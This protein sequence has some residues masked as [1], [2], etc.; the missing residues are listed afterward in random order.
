MKSVTSEISLSIGK[1]FE[2]HFRARYLEIYIRV[3]HFVNQGL[4]LNVR[5]ELLDTLTSPGIEGVPRLW[6]VQ[7]R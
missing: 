4:P 5:N 2:E 3:G 1:T 6:N 7:R